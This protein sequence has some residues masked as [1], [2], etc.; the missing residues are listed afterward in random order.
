MIEIVEY[1][2]PCCSW[3]WG[4]EPKLRSLRWR[5]G[6][7]VAWRIVMGGLVDDASSV[8]EGM[9]DAEAGRRL[10]RYWSRV[11]ELTGMPYPARLQ[12]PPLTSHR[13]GQAV[14][15]AFFQ[16]DDAGRAMLR[17]LRE[18]IFVVGRP[19]DTWE[20]ILDVAMTVEGLDTVAFARDLRSPAAEAAYELDWTETRK[21]NDFVRSLEG[22]WPG[23]GDVK[24]DGD[25]E[26]YA[27]P[28]VIVRGAG[29]ERT[30][31]GWI[32]MEEYESALVDVGV[33]FDDQRPLPAASD[34][35]TT[36]GL[37][38]PAELSALSGTDDVPPDAV[39]FDWGAGEVALSREHAERWGTA[40]W[41]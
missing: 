41:M 34:A 25:H 37:L 7:Q 29:S 33:D 17:A 26:R 32:A 16:G 21:P 38:A 40:G 39:M 19:A 10:A 22:D 11:T 9:D 3:A 28:T 27:F 20:R 30:L 18:A 6:H 15:A 36:Y 8:Y 12:W 1:T 5:F 35:L 2:D 4:S 14:R 31:P 23:I 24:R 13:M